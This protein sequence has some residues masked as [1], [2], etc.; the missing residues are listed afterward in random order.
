MYMER[1]VKPDADRR[2][3]STFDSSNGGPLRKLEKGETQT[4]KRSWA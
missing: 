1:R 2:D 4:R 3:Q